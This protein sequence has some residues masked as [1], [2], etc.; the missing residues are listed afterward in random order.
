MNIIGLT[1]GI[2]SGKSTVSRCLAALGARIIDADLIAH[3]II[4]PEE[5][6]YQEIIEHFGQD[7][8]DANGQVDRVKLG[9]IVFKQPDE[10]QALNSITH[11]HIGSS[12][13]QHIKEAAA[14]GV[15][16]AVLD[17]PLLY[18]VGMD[19]LADEVWVVWVEPEVQLQRLMKRDNI[20]ES[21]ARSRV[22]SQMPLAEKRQRAQIVIDNNGDEADTCQQVTRFYNDLVATL[23]RKMK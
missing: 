10:L 2:A 4:E 23:P 21:A 18:E 3:Q 1:G 9:T 7:I 20:T 13:R 5:P 17:V 8:L 19:K 22:A 11:P 14:A 16:V 12:I 15:E 6:A